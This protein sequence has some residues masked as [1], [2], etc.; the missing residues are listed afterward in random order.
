VVVTRNYR[1]QGISAFADLS[2]DES[3]TA[4]PPK[5]EGGQF[6]KA[7]LRDARDIRA[8]SAVPPGGCSGATH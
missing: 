7:S 1:L 3:A 8:R 6:A 2:K 5:R 4:D